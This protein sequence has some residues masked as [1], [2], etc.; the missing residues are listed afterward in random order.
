MQCTECR[1][2]GSLIDGRL[3]CCPYC[4]EKLSLLAKAARYLPAAKSQEHD[5]ATR[6]GLSTFL[7]FRWRRPAA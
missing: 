3:A 5:A 1:H 2:C 6:T 7:N 4:D